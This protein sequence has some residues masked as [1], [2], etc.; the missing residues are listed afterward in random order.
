MVQAGH[1]LVGAEDVL[2]L[3]DVRSGLD[4]LKVELGDAVDVFE[5]SREL[6]RHLLHLVVGELEPGKLGDMQDLV[7]V[8]HRAH[9]RSGRL[10]GRSVDVRAPLGERLLDTARFGHIAENVLRADRS[11]TPL[12]REL[13]LKFRHC[14]FLRLSLQIRG[15]GLVLN[16]LDQELILNARMRVLLGQPRVLQKLLVFV[17]ARVLLTYDRLELSIDL[18]L[19][20]RN[21]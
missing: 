17:L 2:E 7:A 16:S 4:A 11:L 21:A 19:R 20:Y 8:D 14:L 5:D 6:P 1:R 9:V 13:L 12:R 15:E 3:D 18:C 10:A